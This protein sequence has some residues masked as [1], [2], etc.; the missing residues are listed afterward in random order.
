MLNLAH[1]YLLNQAMEM[2]KPH[3]T[4]SLSFSQVPAET[5]YSKF[6]KVLG[7]K[8][9]LN[10]LA[11][12]IIRWYNDNGNA[13]G[14]TF[15]YRFTGKD[16]RMFLHNFM[17]LIDVLENGVSGKASKLLHVHA[18]LCLCLRNVVSLFSRVNITDDQVVELKQHC[19]NFH[20]SYWLHIPLLL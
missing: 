5:P 11:K 7:S 20:C 19:T 17:Y 4:N 18:Y 13:N 10:R 9:N 1:R 6:I 14:R 8:C 15:D 16:S 12:R 2:S 3:L